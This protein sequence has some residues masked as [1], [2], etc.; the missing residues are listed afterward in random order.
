[1]PAM[2]VSLELSP[3]GNVTKSRISRSI[4]QDAG[5]PDKTRELGRH[6]EDKRVSSS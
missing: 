1:M 5:F 6:D 2:M 4:F 3:G